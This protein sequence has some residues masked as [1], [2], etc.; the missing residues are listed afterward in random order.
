M[1]NKHICIAIASE[2]NTYEQV[3]I[4]QTADTMLTIEG[5][6]ASFVVAKRED[7]K[8]SIS[9]RSNGDINVQIIME[10]LNG[11]GHLTNAATQLDGVTLIEVEHL[12]KQKID[13]YLEGGEV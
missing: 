4:A 10:Q 3:L 6:K 12:L 1:Y 13:T 5:V 2:E 8:I 9:A 11:G 7:Q